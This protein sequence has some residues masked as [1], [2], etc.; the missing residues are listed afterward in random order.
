MANGGDPY[1]SQARLERPA[2]GSSVNIS[3]YDLRQKRSE[4]STS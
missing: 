3:E 2:S 1:A 4:A